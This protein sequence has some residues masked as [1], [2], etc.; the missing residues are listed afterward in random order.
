M[1]FQDD[2]TGNATLA[3]E[4]VEDI[5]KDVYKDWEEK[6]EKKSKH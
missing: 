3:Y 2:G 5:L 1:C 4:R 6:R